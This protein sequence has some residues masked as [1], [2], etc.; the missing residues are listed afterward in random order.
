M[1]FPLF[2]LLVPQI[3]NAAH[4]TVKTN[5]AL[6][7]INKRAVFS[8]TSSHACIYFSLSVNEAMPD[9]KFSP[10]RPSVWR[11]C[12]F[13]TPVLPS[14]P[15][16]V[17][18]STVQMQTSTP[19]AK[20]DSSFSHLNFKH[21]FFLPLSASTLILHFFYSWKQLFQKEKKI[22]SNSDKSSPAF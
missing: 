1:L 9:A 5:D 21:I 7:G 22:S 12:E 11:R 13:L 16:Q 17:G 8:H 3:R 14:F 15:P 2:Q 18:R 19:P 6:V 4:V 10:N 20:G